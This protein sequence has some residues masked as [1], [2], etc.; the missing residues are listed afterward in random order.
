MGILLEPHLVLLLDNTVIIILEDWTSNP[1]NPCRRIESPIMAP[2]FLIGV[3][4]RCRNEC[5][6]VLIVVVYYHSHFPCAC[7]QWNQKTS[8]RESFLFGRPQCSNPPVHFFPYRIC[9]PGTFPHTAPSPVPGTFLP[10]VLSAAMWTVSWYK[11]C[12]RW[13][14]GEC[15]VTRSPVKNT[16]KRTSCV[17]FAG[18]FTP[19]I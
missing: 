8:C 16:K 3:V 5:L 9:T 18:H 14:N 19:R 4:W 12:A 1:D 11:I 7:A 13:A 6:C 15:V 10:S 17:C 2:L